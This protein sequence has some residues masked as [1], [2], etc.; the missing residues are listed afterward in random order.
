MAEFG[1]KFDANEAKSVSEVDV[2]TVGLDLSLKSMLTQL[3]LAPKLMPSLIG[4]RSSDFCFASSSL[5]I[6]LET[7]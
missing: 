4:F 7:G 6:W 3:D 2:E 1:S 5:E